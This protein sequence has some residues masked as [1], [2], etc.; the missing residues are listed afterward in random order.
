MGWPLPADAFG[1]CFCYPLE[2]NLVALGPRGRARLRRTL[3]LDVHALLQ[4]MKPHP[5]FRRLLEGGELRRVG[6]QDDPR[7]RLLRAARA[8]PR[9][10][11][12]RRS[13][14]RRAS[15]TCASLKGIHYAMQSGIEAARAIFA[16]AEGGRHLGR[17]ARRLRRGDATPRYVDEDLR[18]RRN[19]RLAF[20]RGFFLRRR[21]RRR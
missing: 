10:R 7:G 17:G 14:T 15:W 13:A 4:R 9:R 6:R 8:A 5:L 18:A 16:R 21:S 1:G 3:D 12:A 11:R 19:M 20:K 2:K